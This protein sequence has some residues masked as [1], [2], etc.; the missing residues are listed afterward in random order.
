MS[1]LQI[2]IASTRPG[3]AGLPVGRWFESHART[4]GGFEEIDVADLLE[5][6]LP[7]M[8]EPNHPR[9]RQYTQEHTKAWSAR[10]Q[11]AD[12]FA[13][14]IPEYNYG[15]P[16]ALLNALDYLY[17]EWNY[18]PATL[19]SYGQVSAGLRSAQMVKQVAT[20]LKMF[21]TAEAVSIPFV[22][23]FL[24]DEGEFRPNEQLEQGATTVLDELVRVGDA[25]AVL[26]AQG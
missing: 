16:P 7:F 12:A 6:G 9:M 11:A 24:D 5:I 8:D 3:R 1:T 10:V 22:G 18:K 2:V 21:V 19:V 20:T 25:L 13:F 4:H 15:P 23:Q 14:V 26:R 17:F